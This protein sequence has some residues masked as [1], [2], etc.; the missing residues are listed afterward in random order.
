M[1]TI[2]HQGFS[3]FPR[4]LR[5]DLVNVRALHGDVYGR[6]LRRWGRRTRQR[7]LYLFGSRVRPGS[8][9]TPYFIWWGEVEVWIKSDQGMG[10]DCKPVGY[11]LNS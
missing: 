3:L 4:F 9:R 11:V 5:I 1:E 10:V 2:F 6:G 8:A 7:L